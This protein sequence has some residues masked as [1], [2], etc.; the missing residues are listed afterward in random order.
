MSDTTAT[1]R[2]NYVGKTAAELGLTQNLESSGAFSN[3]VIGIG[4]KYQIDIYGNMM[5][6]KVEDTPL[7]TILSN[8][9]TI[10]AA[11]PYIVWNDEYQGNMWWDIAI[12]NL[13][14]RDNKSGG[15]AAT[16]LPMSGTNSTYDSRLMPTAINTTAYVGGKLPVMS[17]KS[18]PNSATTNF[19]VAADGQTGIVVTSANV[20]LSGIANTDAFGVA[21]SPAYNGGTSSVANRPLLLFKKANDDTVG[22]LDTVWNRLHQLA[23][24]LGYTKVFNSNHSDPDIRTVANHRFDYTAAAHAPIYM[25][26]D[27]LHVSGSGTESVHYQALVL[28]N[29]VGLL[30]TTNT[31]SAIA[32]GTYMYIEL[33][34]SVSNISPSDVRAYHA[35]NK[36]SICVSVPYIYGAGTLATP[37]TAWFTDNAN[38]I[39]SH[40]GKMSRMVHVGRR[41]SAPLPIPEGDT[42][43]QGGNFTAY[44]ERLTNCSQ[45]FATPSYGITGTHQ[46]SNF[47][48]GDD[49][50]RTRAMWLELYK[51]WK[52]SAFLFG[53]K[54]E[55]AATHGTE[56]EHFMIG[57][58]VRSLG[59][60]MDYALFPINYMKRPLASANYGSE[61]TDQLKLVTWLDDVADSLTAFK[62]NGS[63]DLTFLVSLSFLRR[64][65]PYTRTIMNNGAIMGGQVNLT[66]PSQLTFG[67][68]VYEFVS[69][70][71]VKMKF[72]HDK[73]LD[74]LPSLPVPYWIFGQASLNPREVLIS[75]DT[76]NIKQVICRPDRIYGNVQQIGQDAFM[77]GMRGE[78]SFILRYPKN[79]TILWAPVS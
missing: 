58:P 18:L 20:V 16:A 51:G 47:R 48:F 76:N 61:T 34:L 66:K 36:D 46:A 67:L 60:L 24:N 44:R 9:G 72:I 35:D 45:I 41:M 79:H 52:E 3:T 29:K 25:A 71:G 8:L 77:E 6:H 38:G 12:D 40:I 33:D 5:T 31:S 17:V 19:L 1:S 14:L 23:T 10:S 21:F 65:I 28:I 42:F 49:F 68:E 22:S 53:V 73:S 15:A 62:S 55:T 74:Y 43:T 2:T 26:F 63:Q 56:T 57:Q 75:I 70:A 50:Q 39:P 4:D 37:Y 59:G 13:R 78:S 27:E 30:T 64:L 32:T 11:P 69:S 7:L 54:G